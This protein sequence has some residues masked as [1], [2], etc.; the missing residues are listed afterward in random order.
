MW[1]YW[2]IMPL[3]S[4]VRWCIRKTLNLGMGA[5]SR[6]SSFERQ[7]Q[8]SEFE[9]S[10]ATQWDLIASTCICASQGTA[11]ENQTDSHLDAQRINFFCLSI[12]LWQFIMAALVNQ[13]QLFGILLWSPLK[14]GVQISAYHTVATTMHKCC[15]PLK[16][17]HCPC[18]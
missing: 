6:C 10:W 11:W 14:V 17:K 1:S 8:E 5:Q 18:I 15:M 9:D 13:Q 16:N 3:I 2:E 7:R 12:S 4:N